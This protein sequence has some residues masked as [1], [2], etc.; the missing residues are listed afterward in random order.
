MT[1]FMKKILLLFT[2]CLL[3]TSLAAQQQAQ[4]IRTEVN[5]HALHSGN[6]VPPSAAQLG[7][8]NIPGGPCVSPE[9]FK[10]MWKETNDNIDRLGLRSTAAAAKMAATPHP[11]FIFPVQ[12]KASFTGPGYY[13]I[14]YLVDQNM[15]VNNHLLDY[16][17]G[18]RTYDGTTFNH[19]G[20]DIVL[21]PYPWRRMDEQVME[22][23][24]GAPG[25]IVSKID[26]NYDRNCLNNGSGV[27]NA[28]HVRHADGS[29]AWY[30]HLKTGSL[31]AKNIGD[32]V[33]AGDYL[34]T[35]GSSGS[36]NWPHV[37]FQ[38]MDSMGFVIDPWAGP[39]NSINGND[40]WWVSQ[41]PY[42]MPQVNH[43]CTKKTVYDYYSC[44]V[45]EPQQD[46]D[47]FYL[48][49]T[50]AIWLYYRDLELNS[51]TT[52]NLKNPS[53]QIPI[54]FNF[55]SPWA[56]SP[57]AYAAWYYNVD[58]WWTPGW[59]TFEA[60][61]NGVTYQ[62]SFYITGGYAGLSDQSF[63]GLSLYPN[64]AS[65]KVT[66]S[67][68]TLEPGTT[69]T[70]TSAEGRLLQ[71]EIVKEPVSGYELDIQGY[72]PGVYFVKF[73]QEGRSLTRRLIIE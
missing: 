41:Q 31:T 33:A 39:C 73:E 11:D 24:A 49:D 72:A 27:P 4:V 35:A 42:N 14:N 71:A 66:V 37:H 61:F 15:T 52:I 53:G 32:S 16:N 62:H 34:G 68:V 45:A 6:P 26:N 17:C 20:T 69:L 19:E 44:P 67:G 29:I 54:T 22:I 12:P 38:V 59:W 48:G 50:L 2:T 30:W 1:E 40:S 5:N 70:I 65:R 56:T 58:G 43:I 18:S 7:I 64:P 13:T 25:V 10:Q 21:W 3:V 51:S 23:I 36:S 55:I 46:K 28:V 47:T 8:V 63:A 9:V 57:T 60:I